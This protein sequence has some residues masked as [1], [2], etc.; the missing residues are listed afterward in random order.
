MNDSRYS[1]DPDYYSLEIE[2]DE[3]TVYVDAP[4]LTNYEYDMEMNDGAHSPVAGPF[5]P[6]PSS[7]EEESGSHTKLKTTKKKQKV[8]MNAITHSSSRCNQDGTWK[9]GYDCQRMVREWGN[10]ATYSNHENVAD[11]E[12]YYD[13]CY[14]RACVLGSKD[15]LD[16]YHGHWLVDSGRFNHITPY[17]DDFLNLVQGE[18]YASIANSAVVKMTG[19]GTIVLWQNKLQ[20]P[21]I[22]LMEVWLKSSIP[23][24]RKILWLVALPPWTLLQSKQDAR[25][26]VLG[27]DGFVPREGSRGYVQALVGKQM[28]K[29]KVHL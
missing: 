14:S 18:Q 4:M 6:D 20:A 21:P 12:Y 3:P 24:E 13:S 19:P 15:L 17:L 8:M 2:Y 23:P 11:G 25:C 27:C 1:M 7:V 5:G 16:F 9:S 29:E 26:S 22:T 10:K 28:V